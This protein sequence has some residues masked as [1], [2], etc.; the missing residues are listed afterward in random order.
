MDIFDNAAGVLGSDG[1]PD[2]LADMTR[3]YNAFELTLEKR[4]SQGFQFLANYR[5]AKVWGNWEGLFRN[6]NGQDDPFITSLFDFRQD[7]VTKSLL[8]SYV[9]GYLNTDRRHVLNVNGSY[10]MP[11]KLTIGIGARLTSGYPLTPIGTHPASGY[12]DNEVPMEPRGSAGRS[13]WINNIDVHADY[14]FT[15]GDNYRLRFAVD[16][17]NV[18]NL[19][20]TVDVDTQAQTSGEPYDDYLSPLTF[21]RPFN[22]R[23]SIRFEF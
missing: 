5:L 7:P 12:G 23:L 13:D 19:K 21:Q 6:D 15:F 4:F 17:F 9:P 8:Y 3:T 22:M 2:G 16:M 20:K 1:I 10:T 18:F 11:N 14:P